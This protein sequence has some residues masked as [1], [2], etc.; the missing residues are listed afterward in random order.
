[1]NSNM[2]WF[3]RLFTNSTR[4]LAR[5]TSRRSF[6]NQLGLVVLGVSAAP[7]LPMAR[8]AAP[9]RQTKAGEPDASTP[10]GDETN[11]EY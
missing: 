2:N 1:M 9:A 8:A 10:Q 4:Q 7:L 3:D 11:C 5:H 6:L